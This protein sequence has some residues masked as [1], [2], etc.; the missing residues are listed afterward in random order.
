MAVYRDD[1]D[2]ANT[3]YRENNTVT[4]ARSNM[5]ALA[6]QYPQYANTYANQINDI[7][8]QIKQ[9]N[10][11]N[12]NP[13]NDAAYRRY[14]EE[15]NALAGLA[16]AGNQ[17]QAQGLTGG[18]GSTYAPEVANQ[19]LARMQAG[20]AGAQPAFLQAAQ[21]AYM[22]NQDQ[23]NNMYQAA[24]NA[25]K[26]E[27]SQYQKAADAYNQRMAF[28]RQRYGDAQKF[29]YQNYN[30]A[31]NA[32]AKQYQFDTELA[33]KEQ[34]LAFE[35]EQAERD[36][37]FKSYEVYNKLAST[38]CSEYKENMDNSGMRAYLDGLVK[39]G[40]ITQYMADTLY[41]QYKYEAPSSGGGGGGGGGRRS[42]G[43]SG[44]GSGS[45]GNDVVVAEAKKNWSPN[46]NVLRT[47][48]MNNRS[49]D[50]VKA[51][52]TALYWVDALVNKGTIP[53]DERENY[54]SYYQ[55]KYAS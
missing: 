52:E 44:S 7:Y 40:K 4:Q 50:K 20:A 54:K 42:S 24:A 53:A 11:F 46:Q 1:Y 8:S 26:N 37:E 43:G 27:L 23:L 33:Q 2:K 9:G 25:Q 16:V 10:D 51:L 41:N 47:I 19:G 38:K 21:S 29:D 31:R 34:E 3:A 13:N 5:N 35:Q 49:H 36:R 32:Y 48:T 28:A 14:A 45:G 17:A 55:S 6:T 18:Y 30:D 22:A 12:Y 15:Y 39:E